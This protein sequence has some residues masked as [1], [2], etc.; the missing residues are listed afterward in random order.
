MFH[1]EIS[2]MKQKERKRNEK[3]A[4][5]RTCIE[6][7]VTICFYNVKGLIFNYLNA[8]LFWEIFKY[9]N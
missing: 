3:G 8:C 2:M 9:E 7:V 6:V 1:F 4:L 5:L